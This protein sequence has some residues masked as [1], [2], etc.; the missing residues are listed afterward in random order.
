V[1]EVVVPIQDSHCNNPISGEP[2]GPDA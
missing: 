2:T 1:L